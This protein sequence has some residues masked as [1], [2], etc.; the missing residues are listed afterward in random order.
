MSL[1]AAEAHRL[2][3]IF[4]HHGNEG[5]NG[6][7]G[8][9]ACTSQQGNGLWYD[10]NSSEV[11]AGV[12]WNT[13]TGN[14]DGCGTP[15]SVTYARFKANSVALAAHYSGN[16]TVIGF[17]LW[18]EP[19]GTAGKCGNGCQSKD[20]NWGGRNGSDLRLMCSDTGTAVEAA[21]PG[22]IYYL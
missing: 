10:V 16:S 7:S 13:L 11:I 1:R 4:S 8:N 19:I 12:T 14:Y 17:D 2:K 15:G 22:G 6:H 21:D 9:A 18:N 5:V 3:V 20:L